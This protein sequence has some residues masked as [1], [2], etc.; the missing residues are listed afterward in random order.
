[1]DPLNT[2]SNISKQSTCREPI[3]PDR[4]LELGATGDY[5]AER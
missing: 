5:V 4:P 1:M 3:E 2:A